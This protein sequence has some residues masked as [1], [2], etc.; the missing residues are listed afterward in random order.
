MIE[1]NSVVFIK[2]DPELKINEKML[3]HI[4]RSLEKEKRDGISRNSSLSS[5]RYS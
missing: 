3:N 4:T 2:K 1:D 5:E